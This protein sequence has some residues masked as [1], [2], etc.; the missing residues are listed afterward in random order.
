LIQL[1]INQAFAAVSARGAFNVI[2]ELIHTK[3]IM[4]SPARRL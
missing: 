3:S 2:A 4:A 1:G